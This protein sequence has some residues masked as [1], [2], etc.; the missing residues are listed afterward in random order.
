MQRRRGEPNPTEGLARLVGLKR[1][2]GREEGS[3]GVPEATPQPRV[4]RN[5]NLPAWK[6]VVIY[7][8]KV[9]LGMQVDAAV[10]YMRARYS[11]LPF[12]SRSRHSRK[13]VLKHSPT[14]SSCRVTFLASNVFSIYLS[15]YYAT[16]NARDKKRATCSPLKR[17]LPIYT[18]CMHNKRIPFI[19]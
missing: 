13:N 15:F 12:L 10:C 11:L 16:E 4:L 8:N 19:R 3:E 14:C 7:L 1:R 5:W 18:T 2:E 17:L 9:H 6:P